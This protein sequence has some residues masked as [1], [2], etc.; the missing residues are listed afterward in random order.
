MIQPA[1]RPNREDDGFDIRGSWRKLR[2][3][4]A[5]HRLL[6]FT[7]TALTVALVVAYTK[8]FPHQ[9]RAAAVVQVE[10]QE[11]PS[12]DIFYSRWQV[13]RKD[14]ASS[15]V[16]LLKAG[17]VIEEV[18]DRLDLGYDDVHRSMLQHATHIWAN[19]WIGDKYRELKSDIFGPPEKSGFE[20]SPE[21]RERARTISNLQLAV[22]IEIIGETRLGKVIVTGP[23]P[24]VAEVANTLVDVYLEQ[25]VEL[26]KAEA[27][28]AREAL[29]VELERTRTEL[30][31]IEAEQEKWFGDEG[32]VFDFEKHRRDIIESRKLKLS[33]TE[34]Q[35]RA[36]HVEKRLLEVTRQ[37]DG[38]LKEL[39]STRTDELNQIKRTV[40]SRLFGYQVAL[41]EALHRYQEDSP[42]IQEIKQTI[43]KLEKRLAEEDDLILASST[44]SLNLRREHLVQAKG[45]LLAEQA[46]A[47]A[48]LEILEKAMQEYRAK[49]AAWPAQ[50]RAARELIRRQTMTESKYK[51][52][53]DKHTQAVLSETTAGAAKPSMRIVERA[54]VPDKAFWP[55]TKLLIAVALVLGYCFGLALAYIRDMLG[56]RLRAHHV[57]SGR[58]PVPLF[59]TVTVGER[60]RLHVQALASSENGDRG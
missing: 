48:S 49:L 32:V 29:G 22:G 5:R 37:I 9:Y 2:G 44:V 38:E 10:P 55:K 51:Q 30:A 31:T 7:V 42:E 53:L 11:D 60:D 50:Q 20:L 57:E 23:S 8:V 39:N 1:V 33:I 25:R 56:T 24:R 26:A 27:R 36:A 43:G 40:E 15:E 52:L 58:A 17:P 21:Q 59:A 28:A 41:A 13:F 6:I 46:G 12:R 47:N 34:G 16:E 54:V 4:S 18:A 45:D 14:D 35:A 3:V 19:C